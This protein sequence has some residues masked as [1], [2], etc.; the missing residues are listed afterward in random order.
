MK[1]YIVLLFWKDADPTQRLIEAQSYEAAIM[2]CKEEYHESTKFTVIYPS[3]IPELRR[4]YK[5]ASD[6]ENNRSERFM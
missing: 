5:E 4:L 2:R 3:M 6:W 1:K